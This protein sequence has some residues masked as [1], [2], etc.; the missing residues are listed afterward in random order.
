MLCSV[1]EE[2]EFDTARRSDHDGELHICNQSQW[3]CVYMCTSQE[4]A[5]IKLLP[6]AR[7]PAHYMRTFARAN[8]A[9]VGMLHAVALLALSWCAHALAGDGYIMHLLDTSGGGVCL[10]GSPGAICHHAGTRH[11]QLIYVNRPS[12][13]TKGLQL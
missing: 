5:C 1:L 11:H 12:H 2:F 8:L 7:H 10:D 9:A 4:H 6:R 3:L 13:Q